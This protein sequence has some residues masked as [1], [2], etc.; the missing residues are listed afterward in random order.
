MV[1][2]PMPQRYPADDATLTVVAVS[3]SQPVTQTIH[4]QPTHTAI[5]RSPSSTP[6]ALSVDNG[7]EGHQSAIHDAQVH[8]F[9][10]QHYDYWTSRLS[11]DRATWNWAFWGENL[12]IQG[13]DNL[14]ENTVYL[15]DR[16]VFSHEGREGVVL[17]VCGGRNPCSRLAWRCGQPH[18]WL[19]EVAKSGFCGIYLRV[20]RGG[21][22]G[23]G[24][25]ARIV[26]TSD[27]VAVP[28]A[29]IAQCA[30]SS[31]ED[32]VTR[33]MAERILH[34][35]G[36]QNMNK[37]VISRK[38]SMLQERESAKH[39][40]WKGWR[41]LEIVKSVDE[42]S[43]VKS[44]YLAAPDNEPLASYL[45]GQFLTIKLPSDQI[46]CWSISSWSPSSTTSSPPFYRITVKK[47]LS[48]SRYLHSEYSV[49]DRLLVRSPSGSFVPDWSREF[50]PR[51]IYISAGIGMTP[52]LSMLQAHFSHTTLKRTPAVLIHVARNSKEDILMFGVDLPFTPF[53]EVIKF[54]TSPITGVDVRGQDFDYEGRPSAVFF[55]TLL[56]PSY[57]IDPL[58]ITPI[59][60]PGNS[61]GAYI[62]GPPAFVDTI[63]VYLE[64]AKLP[65]RAIRT[66]TFSN[67][68]S[69][70]VSPIKEDVNDDVPEECL[71][72]FHG[73]AKEVKWKKREALSILQLAEREGLQPEFGCRMGHCGACEMKVLKGAARIP[74]NVEGQEHDSSE[75]ATTVIRTCCAVPTC[76]TLELDF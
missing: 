8:A 15:N 13:P 66:E 59:E 34:V 61:S 2:T 76:A 75:E 3:R 55:T 35:P 56:A 7:I 69:L 50:P 31:L 65:S 73:K 4:S 40:R 47:R 10:A 22:I 48:A 63:R 38:L 67:D 57:K 49:G 39:G 11:I 16:W 41:A 33:I 70:R 20:V 12:T 18:S 24:D 51:Q 42:S 37:L 32:P 58:Q 23:P 1:E 27:E 46:R 5:V 64:E 17:E 9:F 60:L 45:P 28:A 25:T 14:S 29:S 6:L 72:R 21:S 74:G 19:A 62:C 26:P 30:Y 36:L 43:S 53:L 54:Y 52:I 44:F 68:P 71:V